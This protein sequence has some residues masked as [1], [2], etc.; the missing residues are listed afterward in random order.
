MQKFISPQN[1]Y[2]TCICWFPTCG[3]QITHLLIH[4]AACE[5]CQPQQCIYL[6]QLAMAAGHAQLLALAQKIAFCECWNKLLQT[7]TACKLLS[8]G[9]DEAFGDYLTGNEYMIR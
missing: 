5:L 9:I 3:V 2:V 1:V 8:R 4:E 7:Y 6:E